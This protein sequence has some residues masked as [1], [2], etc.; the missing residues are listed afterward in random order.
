M[1]I[2]LPSIS[3]PQIH[4]K[5][6]NT[7]GTNTPAAI[8]SVYIDG[9]GDVKREGTIVLS[10]FD[11]TYFKDSGDKSI[12]DQYTERGKLADGVIASKV[13]QWA[14]LGYTAFIDPHRP[15]PSV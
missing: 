4:S 9:D 14:D 1:V 6:I 7:I 5:I 10:D 3:Q 8:V 12:G 2:E 13:K 11:S 15:S